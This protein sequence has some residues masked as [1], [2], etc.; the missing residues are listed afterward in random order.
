MN[1]QQKHLVAMLNDMYHS[2]S[3]EYKSR[4]R[5]NYFELL[6]YITSTPSAYITGEEIIARINS[7]SRLFEGRT[8]QEDSE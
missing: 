4:Y 1:E 8:K 2:Q 3:D 6:Q 5:D 7:G